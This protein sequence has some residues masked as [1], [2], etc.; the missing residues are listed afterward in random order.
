MYLPGQRSM[1]VSEPQRIAQ[2]IFSTFSSMEAVTVELLVFFFSSRRRHTRLQ[3]DWSSDV[4]SSD[5]CWRLWRPASSPWTNCSPS[6]WRILVP[7]SCSVP[8]CDPVQRCGG[9]R[10]RC[11]DRGGR[12]GTRLKSRHLLISDAVFFLRKQTNCA[13]DVDA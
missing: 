11:G 6:P 9:S 12:E 4:C 1:T 13:H 2:V 3:G 10:R 8:R 5:L 7:K